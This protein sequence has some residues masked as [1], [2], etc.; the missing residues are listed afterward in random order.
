M[1]FFL[2]KNLS[3]IL[4]DNKNFRHNTELDEIKLDLE[5]STVDGIEDICCKYRTESG[6]GLDGGRKRY[7]KSK[8]KKTKRR[9]TKKLKGKLKGKLKKEIKENKKT[10]KYFY[11]FELF[12]FLFTQIN[13]R[14]VGKFTQKN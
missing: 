1:N 5:C 12:L 9:K 11:K 3:R 13:G 7:K 6:E 8:N 10:L 14:I 4:R 2:M